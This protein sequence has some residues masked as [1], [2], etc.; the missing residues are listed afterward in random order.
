MYIMPPSPDSTGEM[1]YAWVDDLF[2][3]SEL[4]EITS[5]VE[6]LPKTEGLIMK[7]GSEDVRKSKVSWVPLSDKAKFIYDK[8]SMAAS[9]LNSQSF[10]FDLFGFAEPLQ[11]A[12][13]DEQGSHY[14]WHVD[15]LIAN[16]PPRKLSLVL[17]LS[18]PSDHEGGDLEFFGTPPVK[19]ERK[20]GRLVVFP[21]Y[22]L[23]RVTPVEKGIRR[24]LVA[25]VCGN[26]F[27]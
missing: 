11:Y 5:I 18:D 15:K 2:T 13:Y 19:M 3:E 16:L 9:K 21:S 12:V 4:K 17:M 20:K 23:H 24:S 26:K 8:L 25:W 1:E 22:V 14:S 7:G 6:V 27:R 10:Q